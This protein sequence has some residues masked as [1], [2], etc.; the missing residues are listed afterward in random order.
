MPPQ[1]ATLGLVKDNDKSFLIQN[2]ILMV[3][4]LYFYKSRVSGTLN[5]NTFLHQLIKVKNLQKG[6]AF[7]NKQ[8]LDRNGLS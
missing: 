4:Q 3:F 2:V 7:N 1:I 5:L 6:A 8:K